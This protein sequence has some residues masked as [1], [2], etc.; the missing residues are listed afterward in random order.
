MSYTFIANLIEQI[1]E[2]PVNSIVSQ[3][4]YKDPHHQ[5]ILFAF[6]AGQELAEHTTPQAAMLHFVQGEA[7][8]TLDSDALTVQSGSWIYM[9]P[10]LPHSISAK[11]TLLMLL[12][13]VKTAEE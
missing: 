10:H 1:P 12:T 2:I 6:A 3:T 8:V 11:T 7:E 4:I 9:P 13:M 5:T